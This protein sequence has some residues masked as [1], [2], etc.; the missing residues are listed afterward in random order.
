MK[1]RWSLLALGLFGLVFDGGRSSL[2]HADSLTVKVNSVLSQAATQVRGLQEKDGSWN[3]PSYLGTHYLSQYY[4]FLEWM[5]AR[6][7]SRLDEKRLREL[8]IKTQGENGSWI[9][10]NDANRDSS[11]LNAT[12]INYAAL[13]G[14]GENVDGLVLSRA[15]AFILSRG[16]VQAASTFTKVLLALF[17]NAD[18][19]CIPEIPYVIFLEK[20][21]I[22]VSDF[23]QWVGPHIMPIAYLRK[24]Q[25]SKNLGEK[26]RVLELWKK[27]PHIGERSS[28]SLLSG[29]SLLIDKIV[30]LQRPRGSFGAYTVATWLSMAAIWDFSSQMPNYVSVFGNYHKPLKK[31]L[32]FIES[33]YF[34]SNESAYKGVLDDGR[35]WDTAL[36]G[37]ASFEAVKT[38]SAAQPVP[39]TAR[40]DLEKAVSYLVSKQVKNGGLPF[41]WD[42]EYA[43]DTDDTAEMILFL[44]P[45]DETKT[46]RR[47]AVEFLLSMQNSDGGWGA[48]DRNNNGNALLK[49]FAAPFLDSADLF[50][51]SSADVTGHI[52]EA[53]GSQG[54]TVSNS[55]AV[56]DAIE[57]L[58]TNRESHQP[59]WQG[60]WGINTVYATP[61]VVTGLIKVGV[62]VSD[63]MIA[64]ALDW[65]EKIQNADGGFGEGTKSYEDVTHF[66]GVGMSTPSQTA[67][68]LIALVEAGRANSVSA[69]RAAEYLVDQFD[70][71]KL[72]VDGSTVGTG[73][74]GVIYMNYPSYP[75]AFSMTALSRFQRHRL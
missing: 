24:H 71:K 56:R 1:S 34:D 39:E 5:G 57:F 60:R 29:D 45:F 46:A 2:V 28:P 74:P 23:A 68:V 4:L 12:I 72:W 42:F 9:A 70:D 51:D 27:K 33:M 75:I 3:L 17:Q 73:H 32:S 62:S 36:L 25:V 61:A 18:W 65:F 8:L 20:S 10:I 47:K 6:A 30:S 41:G 49:H 38:V 48:F 31:G 43:P 59:C 66:A 54:Y 55:A 67:W 58:K 22:N 19:Q 50:D 37:I 35:Y 15:K 14:M 7:G 40:A 16:G 69:T 21:P 11:D 53:L 13:K 63:P 64:R 26:F 52:L 44:N